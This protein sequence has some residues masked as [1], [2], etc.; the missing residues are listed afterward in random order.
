M[1]GTA[2]MSSK[3]FRLDTTLCCASKKSKSPPLQLGPAA[4]IPETL[5][6]LNS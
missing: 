5:K 3:P 1:R 4:L 2:V 6:T